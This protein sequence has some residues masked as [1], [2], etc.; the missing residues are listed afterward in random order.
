MATRS[1]AAGADTRTPSTAGGAFAARLEGAS[2]ARLAGFLGES[3]AV[4]EDRLGVPE[5]A[6]A[7]AAAVVRN[8]LKTLEVTPVV[9]GSDLA[10]LGFEVERAAPPA[11]PAP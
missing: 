10:E 11:S 1:S 9:W 2:S 5:S 8:G 4:R 6:Q 7:L 3:G